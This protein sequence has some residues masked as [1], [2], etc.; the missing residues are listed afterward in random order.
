MLRGKDTN[1]FT[2]SEFCCQ[3][4]SKPCIVRGCKNSVICE[5][6]FR[7]LW[8][9]Y[10]IVRGNFVTLL[11]CRTLNLREHCIVREGWRWGVKK[12]RTLGKK[13]AALFSCD[14]WVSFAKTCYSSSSQLLFSLSLSSSQLLRITGALSLSNIVFL[15][16]T[17][18]K[19]APFKLAPYRVAL[20]KSA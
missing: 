1:F 6:K 4:S 10:C 14:F 7:D 16:F 8:R 2:D 3:F 17:P 13:S 9:E 11:G 18:C 15:S 19:F 12:N 20:L 5:K